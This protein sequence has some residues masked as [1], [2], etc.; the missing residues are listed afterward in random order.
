MNTNTKEL[1]ETL[2]LSEAH[3]LELIEA[4]LAATPV[5]DWAVDNI[6]VD[7]NGDFHYRKA[8]FYSPKGQVRI[9]AALRYYYGFRD[10]DDPE[11]TLDT[12]I[13]FKTI[14]D[15][16]KEVWWAFGYA[17]Y[18][19]KAYKKSALL[20]ELVARTKAAATD[21]M[22]NANYATVKTNMLALLKG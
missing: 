15:D 5:S 22:Y 18:T 16:G 12:A 13:Q 1:M 11:I 4:A 6:R 10:V 8:N 17:T 9:T 14:N 19:E 20:S 7:K 3:V 2:N 21:D